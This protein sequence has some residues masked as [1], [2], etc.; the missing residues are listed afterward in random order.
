MEIKGTRWMDPKIV[1]RRSYVI[2]G[3]VQQQHWVLF[4]SFN[5]YQL[6]NGLSSAYVIRSPSVVWVAWPE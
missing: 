4:A 1:P 6:L 2:P 5:G 3:Q